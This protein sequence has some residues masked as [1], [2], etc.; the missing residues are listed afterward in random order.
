M[1]NYSSQPYHKTLWSLPLSGFV[2]NAAKRFLAQWFH[3]DFKGDNVLATL[4]TMRL[5]VLSLLFGLQNDPG[6]QSCRFTE[7]V[8]VNTKLRRPLALVSPNDA[9]IELFEELRSLIGDHISDLP[10]LPTILLPSHEDHLSN[11]WTTIYT[12]PKLI[13]TRYSTSIS[14]PIVRFEGTRDMALS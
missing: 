12:G 1:C 11:R 6:I 8:I 14:Y 9:V 13:T 4:Q 10:H 7:G 3:S 5:I 2:H